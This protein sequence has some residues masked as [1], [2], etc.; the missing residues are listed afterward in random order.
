MPQKINLI[1]AVRGMYYTLI[2]HEYL[3]DELDEHKIDDEM[4]TK[5]V[6]KSLYLR[7]MPNM[8]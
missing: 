6:T 2:H 3:I 5:K 4:K 7:C 1:W 8:S